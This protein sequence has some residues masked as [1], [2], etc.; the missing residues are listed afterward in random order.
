MSVFYLYFNNGFTCRLQAGYPERG[1]AIMKYEVY[2]V[3]CTKGPSRVHRAYLDYL[4][5][6]IY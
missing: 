4:Y 1:R 5:S 6:L 3:L 2:C